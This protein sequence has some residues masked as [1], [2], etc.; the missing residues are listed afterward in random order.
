MKVWGI[1]ATVLMIV[2]IGTSV[3]LYNQNKD[4]KSQKSTVETNLS[5]ANA[6]L[7]SANA[8]ISA[9]SQKIA[10]LSIFFSD[11]DDRDTMDKASV[12]IKTIND[13]TLTADLTAMQNAGSN[14]S[15]TKLMQDLIAAA[16]NDLK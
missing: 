4:L 7:S 16:T 1:I 6:S 14:G 13:P 12:I 9:A 3:W 11:V 15:G 8:K 2:F 10:V 5:S